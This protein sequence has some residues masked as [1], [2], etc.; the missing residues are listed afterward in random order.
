MIFLSNW[1]TSLRS[2]VTDQYIHNLITTVSRKITVI[3]YTKKKT[4]KNQQE[5]NRL[6]DFKYTPKR[7]EQLTSI[8][9][10]FLH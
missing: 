3:I 10:L 1:N 4:K 6:F 5:N 9:I 7:K 8:E 2:V